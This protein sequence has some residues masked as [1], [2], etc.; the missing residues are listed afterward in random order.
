MSGVFWRTVQTNINRVLTKLARIKILQ[1]KE[2]EILYTTNPPGS[3]EIV[4]SEQGAITLKRRRRTWERGR[5]C[6]D[7]GEK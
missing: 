2:A 4:S 5:S 6:S 3:W 1:R 7:L